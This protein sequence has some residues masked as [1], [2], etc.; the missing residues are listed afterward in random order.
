[1][2]CGESVESGDLVDMDE[3][4]VLFL[5]LDRADREYIIECLKTHTIPFV[6][7][8]TISKSP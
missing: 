7:P 8:S 3:Y 4:V 1:M 2:K 5:K 6:L